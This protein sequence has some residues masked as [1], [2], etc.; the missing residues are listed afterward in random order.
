MKIYRRDSG[1][2]LVVA[3]MLMAL[4]AFVV[5][6]ALKRVGMESTIIAA[7][8]VS[9]VSQ[10]KV[11][12]ALNKAVAFMRDNSHQFANLFG[13][14]NFYTNFQREAIPLFGD[15]DVSAAQVP[16][17]LTIVG[18][19]DVALLSNEP[20]VF[21]YENFPASID[22]TTNSGIDLI[23]A[24][25][26]IDFSGVK[27]RV[28]LI[29][30]I[31][32]TPAGDTAPKPTTDY[33]PVWRIDAMAGVDSGPRLYAFL[34]GEPLRNSAPQTYWG[35][36]GSYAV[37][38]KGDN[39]NYDISPCLSYN[40]SSGAYSSINRS[41]KC[42]VGSLGLQSNAAALV[43]GS[44]FGLWEQN[45]SSF[46]FNGRVC[47]A[48]RLGGTCASGGAQSANAVATQCT[49]PGCICAGSSCVSAASFA[50]YY[51]GASLKSFA[52]LCPTT[53]GTRTFDRGLTPL[54]TPGCWDSWDLRYSKSSGGRGGKIELAGSGNYYV[55]QITF[56]AKNGTSVASNIGANIYVRAKP[57]AGGTAKLWVWTV[58]SPDANGRDITWFR[59][60]S[61]DTTQATSS[62]GNPTAFQLNLMWSD[63]G[64]SPDT[65]NTFFPWMANPPQ[66]KGFIYAPGGAFSV[67]TNTIS[68]ASVNTVIHGGLYGKGIY[69]TAP[70]RYDEAGVAAG[71]SLPRVV[72]G[73]GGVV[74]EP[75]I[76]LAADYVGPYDL[77]Y[78]VRQSVQLFK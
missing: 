35:V 31:P 69:S 9:S 28:T 67:G 15:N 49:A 5:R 13:K 75:A 4:T 19:A 62:D 71:L 60:G 27:V 68:G 57:P 38:L 12:D 37:S 64:A 43:Q 8:R 17:N 33:T 48:S 65:T 36:Y 78:R 18:T 29:D 77:T 73:G 72:A 74:E 21:G 53:Q 51:S 39:N 45:W 40:S 46:S 26:E 76:E 47:D 66:F 24:L 44:L 7:S 52:S 42:Y 30:A 6:E 61:A 3:L 16:S 22:P 56:N 1:Y 20:D 10:A 59:N 63:S 34:E 11:E 58:T 54:S 23:G 25:R 2:A 41:D 32:V 70:V 55:N 50:D 14:E